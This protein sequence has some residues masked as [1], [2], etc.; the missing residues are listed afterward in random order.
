MS[1]MYPIS[2]LI[3]LMLIAF[4]IVGLTSSGTAA[5]PE[6]L[7]PVPCVVSDADRRIISEA[8]GIS[9]L[10]QDKRINCHEFRSILDAHEAWSVSR[11]DEARRPNSGNIGEDGERIRQQF[12]RDHH[13]NRA[14]LRGLDIAWI[15][16]TGVQMDGA[17][18]TGSG[19]RGTV[20]GSTRRGVSYGIN[21]T[22]ARL[23][24]AQVRSAIAKETLLR[25]AILIGVDFTNTDLSGAVFYNADLRWANLT[26]VILN[27]SDF[28]G[29][30]LFG[31][32]FEP[33]IGALPNIS[34][35]A[36]AR[37]LDRLSYVKSPNQL[38]QLRS[39]FYAAGLDDQARQLTYAI[40]HTRRTIDSNGNITGR[41]LSY[42]RLVSVEWTTGY[43]IYPYRPVVILLCLVPIFATIYFVS[44]LLQRSHGLWLNRPSGAINRAELD[45]WVPVKLVIHRRPSLRMWRYLRAAFWF[46]L[47]C[48]FRIGFRE[49]NVGEWITRLQ[50]REY[51]LGATGWCRTVAGVQS[52]I[53]VYLLALSILCLFGRPFG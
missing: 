3:H 48:A 26:D 9:R 10:V 33:K 15:D 29:A 28:S 30:D 31:V 47:I 11:D 50:P 53:S 7:S 12:E 41:L 49:V 46:S 14:D 51:V 44:L 8:L 43:G 32:I 13:L 17:N 39:A 16:L 27:N 37:N 4:S 34:D 35:I 24:G 22:R 45:N 25:G 36:S 23:T 20:D 18:I 21:L 2:A 40:E 42:L 6:R 5:G 19:V 38:V 52:L 1:R